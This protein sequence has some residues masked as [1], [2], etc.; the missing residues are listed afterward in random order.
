MAAAVVIGSSGSKDAIAGI[1]RDLIQIL[2]G[3]YKPFAGYTI[4]G[5]TI[6]ATDPCKRVI[7]NL[8]RDRLVS[9]RSQMIPVMASFDQDLSSV[10]AAAGAPSLSGAGTALLMA[11]AAGAALLSAKSE[12]AEY[13]YCIEMIALVIDRAADLN[14]EVSHHRGLSRVGLDSALKEMARV[15][16]TGDYCKGKALQDFFPSIYSD[17]VLGGDVTTLRSAIYERMPRAPK[18]D[19]GRGAE[20]SFSDR[21]DV[22]AGM[23]LL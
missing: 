14:Y 20:R 18:A 2:D 17:T 13:Q 5:F 9:I 4:C 8:L 21:S 19:V 15:F 10:L 16:L 1:A 12:F 11:P 22:T 3:S 7:F 6:C 23:S